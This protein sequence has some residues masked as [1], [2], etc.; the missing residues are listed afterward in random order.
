MQKWNGSLLRKFDDVVDGNA[1]VGTTV[2]VRNTVGNTLAVIYDVDDT[3]SVQKNNPFVTDDFGRYSFFAPNG[4]YTIEFGDGSDSIEISLVDNLKLQELDGLIE[5]SDLDTVHARNIDSIK[6]L[7]SYSPIDGQTFKVR[8]FYTGSFLGGGEFVWDSTRSKALHNG[9]TILDPVRITAW[10]GTY[11]DLSTLYT[12]GSGL[13]C[14]VRVGCGVNIDNFGAVLSGDGF[15]DPILAQME[16][17]GFNKIAIDLSLYDTDNFIPS[18]SSIRFFGSGRVKIKSGQIFNVSICDQDLYAKGDPIRMAYTDVDWDWGTVSYLKSIGFNSVMTF[19]AFDQ[20]NQLLLL[21]SVSAAKMNM[22]AYSNLST[23]SLPQLI[24]FNP[25]VIAYYIYDEPDASLTPIATQDARITSYRSVTG[26]SLACSVAVDSGMQ[27][28]VSEN[29]DLVFVQHYYTEGVTATVYNTGT[30]DRDNIAKALHLQGSTQHKM[31]KSKIIPIV[32]LFTN[33]NFTNNKSKLG[34]FASD[35]LRLSNNG[36][37]AMFAWGG[38]TDP[39]NV[40]SPKNDSDLLSFSKN[41]AEGF[42]TRSKIEVTP[43]IFASDNDFLGYSDLSSHPM[44]TSNT[45]PIVKNVK[46][47]SVNNVG[48][49]TDEFNSDF[50]EQGIAAKDVGGY[51]LINSQSELSNGFCHGKF[52]YRD[53]VDNNNSTIGLSV[54]KD[55]GFSVTDI[56]TNGVANGASVYMGFSPSFVPSSIKSYST[57]IKFVP[58]SANA[59][60]WKFIIG[61]Y[62]LSNWSDKT[63]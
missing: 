45:T 16:L 60:Y 28:L 23:A 25:N 57:L 37:F 59:N 41:L 5:P 2:V 34:N 19:G 52:T 63:Y 40:L 12:T 15:I 6:S 38:A 48:V 51:I 8:G 18:T 53:E 4:K 55:Y 17:S 32:G 43:L 36:S 26:K 50:H 61:Y 35:I 13:G 54:T 9:G 49:V 11:G 31:S 47:F 30:L 22:V 24:D 33:V 3:N 27:Q 46:L 14:F 58:S 39:N 1:S 29:F 20:S 7:S 62:Y 44:L 21:R 42:S 10:D 56:I